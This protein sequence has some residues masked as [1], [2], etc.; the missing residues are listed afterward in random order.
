MN[1]LTKKS[2]NRCYLADVMATNPDPEKH[3]SEYSSL[4]KQVIVDEFISFGYPAGWCL[5]C[6]VVL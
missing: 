4:K 1:R 2:V 6:G 5:R 3:Q